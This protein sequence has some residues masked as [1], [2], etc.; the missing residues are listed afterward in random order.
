VPAIA[1]AQDEQQIEVLEDIE[2]VLA[3]ADSSSPGF[4]AGSIMRADC[5]YLVRI[6]AEDGSSE[7]WASCILNDEPVEIPENQGS[8]PTEPVVESGGECIWSSDYHWATSGMPVWASEFETVSLPSGRVHIWAAF[9]AEPLECVMEEPAESP[10]AEEPAES[11]AAEE[12]EASPGA[13]E[14]EA[15]PEA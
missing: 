2:T 10:A 11:P 8:I 15:S 4:P 12:P 13:E 6:E 5:P 9:P 14:P 1:V 7:E 3:V